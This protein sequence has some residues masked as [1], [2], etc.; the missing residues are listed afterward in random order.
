MRTGHVATL[1]LSLVLLLSLAGPAAAQNQ[2]VA[3]HWEDFVHYVRIAKPDLALAQAQW[4]IDQAPEAE[5]LDAVEASRVADSYENV[6][7]LGKKTETLRDTAAKLEKKIQDARFKRARDPERIKQDIQKLAQGERARRNALE[8]LRVAG[9]FAS[10]E[11]LKTLLNPDESKLHPH[12]LGAMIAI[13][14]DIVYPLSEALASLEPVQMG[15]VAEVIGEIG[16]PR[17]LPYLKRVI[18]D[19]KVD[20]HAKSIVTRAYQQIAKAQS[21]PEELTAAQLYLALG[22]NFYA[23]AT[24]RGAVL[25][26]VDAV[27]NTGVI[28]V[29]NLQAGLVDIHVPAAIFGDV[30]AHRAARSALQ[31]APDMDQAL[32]LWLMSNLRRENRLADGKDASYPPAW[33]A[34]MFYL[35]ASHPHRAHDVLERALT[36]GDAEL[37]RDAIKALSDIAGTDQLVNKEGTIQPLLRALGYPDRRVRYEAAFAMTNARPKAAF[38][39]SF[40]VVPVLAEAVRQTETRFA[41]VIAS[42]DERFGVMK[43]QLKDLGYSAFG[44]TSLEKS[45][46]ELNLKPGIDIIVTD[47]DAAGVEKLYNATVEDYKLSAVPV[48][49]LGDKTTVIR[50]NDSFR[51][52]RRVFPVEVTDDAAKLKPAFEQ[53]RASYVGKEIAADEANKYASTALRL[54]REVAMSRDEVFNVLDAQPALIEALKDTRQDI[55]AQ[56]GGVLALLN[57]EDSQRALAT[58]ALDDSRPE[59]TRIALLGSVAESATHWGSKLNEVQLD[60]LRKLLD[61]TKGDL[62]LASARAF[63]AHSQPTAKVVDLITK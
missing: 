3:A 15:Q 37:A 43:A 8:R 56:A 33:N 5:L 12:V 53:A 2:S 51:D 34:P 6:L 49:A 58:A 13:G 48:V 21:V 1:S 36:D 29:Y 42:S 25:P 45:A 32:S 46:D 20:P 38:P 9:Q 30:L 22:R 39:G 44:G 18:E 57:T 16:Y 23:A 11:L 61:T 27:D 54:L 62:G 50:L 63:G 4:L 26:G 47:H 7:E 60:N 10:K 40:R 14:R 52:N 24:G 28:W 59:E 55:V 19:S 41:L 17:A 35:K 31:L